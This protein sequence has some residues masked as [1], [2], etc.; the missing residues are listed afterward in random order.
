MSLGKVVQIKVLESE[1]QLMP[2]AVRSKL[3]EIAGRLCAVL[4]CSLL[5][6]AVCSKTPESLK[7]RFWP[8]SAVPALC[9]SARMP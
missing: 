7:S 1:T 3:V 4:R 2:G 9:C 6:C 5:F 8:T